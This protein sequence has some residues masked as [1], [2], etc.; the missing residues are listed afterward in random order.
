[1]KELGTYGQTQLASLLFGGLTNYRMIPAM[2]ILATYKHKDKQPY[3]RALE[4]LKTL[5]HATKIFQE[6]VSHNTILE[7]I[8]AHKNWICYTFHDMY[9][10]HQFLT[11]DL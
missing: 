10:Y 5:L 2:H 11:L 8:E 7:M 9:Y 1:M 4:G 3:L 6:G